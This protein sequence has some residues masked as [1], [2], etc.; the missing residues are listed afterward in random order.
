LGGKIVG[1]YPD[2]PQ[3]GIS[4]SFLLALWPES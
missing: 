3:K 1:H 4:H 2:L